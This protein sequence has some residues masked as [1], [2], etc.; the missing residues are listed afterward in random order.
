MECLA[1][2]QLEDLRETQSVSISTYTARIKICVAIGEDC[3]D[4]ATT[5][6]AIR[7]VSDEGDEA[8]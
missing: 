8:G 7:G 1:V 4:E 6:Q 2:V 3:R 5:P